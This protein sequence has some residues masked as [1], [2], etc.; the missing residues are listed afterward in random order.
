MCGI[1]AYVGDRPAWP[2]VVEGLRR[3]EYRGYDSA[4]VAV[5]E[6]EGGLQLRKTVGRVNGLTDDA[7]PEP[8]G[9]LAVGHTRWATHGRPSESNAHPHTDCSGTIA[10]AHNGIIENYLALKSELQKRGHQFKSETDTEVISHLIEE[11][12]NDGLPLQQA[13]LRMGQLVSGPQAVVAV[14]GGD[15]D[16]ICALRLGHAGGIAVAHHQG[17]SIVSSDLPAL[18]PLIGESGQLP[19]AFLE[20]GEAAVINRQGITFLDSSGERVEKPMRSVSLEDVLIDRGGYRHF[21]LKEIMEQP[22]AVVAAMRERVDFA[23]RRVTLPDLGMTD[24]EIARLRRVVLIGC[25]TSLNAA[26]VGRHLIERLAGIPA[27]AESASEYRYRE[28]HLD[29]ATLVVAI[30]Q[31]GETADTVAAMEQVRRSGARLITICN[32]AG[33]QATRL[34]DATLLMRS[35]VEVGVAS[36]KTLT[37]SLTILNL[38]AIRLGF[39]RRH[40][41]D[42]TTVTL[43]DELARLPGRV[44]KIVSEPERLEALAR[45]FHHYRHFLYLGRGINAPIAAEGAL[46]LK[47]ISYI[48]AEA[49]PAGEM[50]HGPIALID[51]EMPTLAIATRD[52]LYDKM[53]NNIQ[54]VKA[55]D[56]TVL[57]MLTEGDDELASLVD[58]VI[59]VPDAPWNLTPILATIPLQLFA[60]YIAVRRGCDV[61]QPRNLAKSVTVE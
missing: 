6:P 51:H 11:G 53:A 30:G 40:L 52:V 36:S 1:V 45:Q 26:Q 43:V 13:V 22:Q 35:G 4:G 2:I 18:L 23:N 41:D 21:M 48:H 28:P 39:A 14:Q 57:A 33:S 37:A 56:G 15:Q 55:R 42:A 49:Y 29:E 8:V 34:A 25:G 58:G 59:S 38:L 44:A 60:Y 10:V 32:A 3:L 12:V 17:Q 16:S 20:D 54:E 31:S 47:E 61:D 27:E 24:A 50:K 46:K 5:L 7:G 9:L 19:V